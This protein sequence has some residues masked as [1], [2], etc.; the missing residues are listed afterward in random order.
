VLQTG[1]VNLPKTVTCVLLRHGME[2]GRQHCNSSEA[3]FSGALR[4]V[5]G[6]VEFKN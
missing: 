4:V 1:S 2:Y 6:S 3:F 5:T